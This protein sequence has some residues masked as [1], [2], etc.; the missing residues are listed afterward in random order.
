M[1]SFKWGKAH[2]VYLPA[3]DAE[4]RNLFRLA[5]DLQKSIA[6][7]DDA[8]VPLL[9]RGVLSTAEVHFTGEERLMRSMEYPLYSW[10]RQQHDTLRKRGAEFLKRIEAGETDA[11]PRLLDFLSVWFRDHMSLADRMMG[12]F[13]RNYE[14][15]HST[16][17]S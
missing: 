4:H 13:V 1:S 9:L 15:L 17:A 14:R 2:A 3:I 12:A 5:E 8:R 6:A 11:A 10:H 16:L 7:K